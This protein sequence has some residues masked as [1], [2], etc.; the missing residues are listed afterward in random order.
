MQLFLSLLLF[1][2][3]MLMAQ[4]AGNFEK[5]LA[6][7]EQYY[8]PALFLTGHGPK[9]KAPLAVTRFNQT[10]QAFTE[11]YQ[12][13]LRNEP[14]AS[15]VQKIDAHIQAAARKV[16]EGKTG[17]AHRELEPIRNIL[18]ELRQKEGKPTVMDALTLFHDHMEV[19]VKTLR[20]K[21]PEALS[22]EDIQKLTDHAGQAADAWKRVRI[23]EAEMALYG[24]SAE[25]A[26]YLRNAITQQAQTIQNLLSALKDKN[27]EEISRQGLALRSGFITIF[28]NLGKFE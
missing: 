20:R 4:P 14:W 7:V 19:I 24:I 3:G 26:Q 28:R 16:A 11:K 6:E 10:W 18:A 13:E 2:A 22:E 12:V 27:K 8:I 1:S 17:P 9:E 5:D 21:K 15:A 25:S 23:G